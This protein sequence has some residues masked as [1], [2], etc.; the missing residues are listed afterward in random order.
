V[1]ESVR[2]LGQHYRETV[3][4]SV[5]SIWI[6]GPVLD[7]QEFSEES[8]V[9]LAIVVDVPGP[10]GLNEELSEQWAGRLPDGICGV[11]DVIVL[12][13]DL[14]AGRRVPPIRIA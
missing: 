11:L 8:D 13:R 7:T 10:G 9:D 6:H 2:S 4:G 12:N 14:P 5:E 1:I 3:G